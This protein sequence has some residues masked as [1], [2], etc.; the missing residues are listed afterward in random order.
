MKDWLKEL[1]W[2]IIHDEDTKFTLAIIISC[3]G[4]GI[5]IAILVT[6]FIAR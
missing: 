1:A 6:K 5:N 3:I 2:A 4:L